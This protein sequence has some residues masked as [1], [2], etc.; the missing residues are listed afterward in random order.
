MKFGDNASSAV[1]SSFTAVRNAVEQTELRF[2]VNLGS[3][4]GS[5]CLQDPLIPG[6]W[7]DPILIKPEDIMYV[8]VSNGM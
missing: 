5:L 8:H 1:R 4:T 2:N 3:Q 7:V 6:S